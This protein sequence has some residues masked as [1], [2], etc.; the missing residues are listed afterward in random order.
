MPEAEVLTD[1]D[2]RHLQRT[3]EDV[4]DEILRAAGG[5][6]LV[7]REHERRVE[8]EAAQQ[9]ELALDRDDVLGTAIRPDDCQRIA[10]EGHGDRAAPGGGGGFLQPFDDRTMTRVDTIELADG[11]GA[12]AE[13]AG[14]LLRAAEDDHA[15]TSAGIAASTGRCVRSHQ[16]PNT[17]RTS[18]MNR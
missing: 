13:S 1:Q 15:C 6:L 11:D 18:G 12:R 4:D 9:L 7:E 14:N 5:H 8:P 10:V 2:S 16:I 3:D 17:G